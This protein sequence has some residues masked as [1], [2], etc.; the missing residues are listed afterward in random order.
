MSSEII[1]GVLSLFVLVGIN[2]FF[3]LAEY[4]LAVSRRTRIQELAANGNRRAQ[5]VA[6]AMED[7]DRFFAAVQIGVTLTSL[8]IGV[9]SEPSFSALIGL[10]LAPFVPHTPASEALMTIASGILGLLIAS[11]F[12]IVLAELTPRAIT[13]R[14]AE[15]IAL[16]V[17]PVMNA[18]AGAFQPFARLLR[19]SSM[20]VLRLMGFSTESA[21]ERLHTIEELKLIV[22]ASERG[23]AINAEQSDMLSGV[24]TLS[25]VSVREIMVPRTEMVCISV[26]ASLR[27]AAHLFA[28]HAYTR[29]P[30][31]EDSLDNIVGVLHVKNLVHA[32][33]CTTRE[34]S[35]RDLMQPP[36]FVPDTQRAD[37]L[38]HQ[39]R[40]RHEYMAIVL[41]EYGGTAGLVTLSDLVSLIIGEMQE[42]SSSADRRS[43]NIQAT[44]DGY[45]IK[46]LT[47]LGDVNEAFGLHLDDPHYDTI[48]G[49]VM[50]QLGRI[51]NV[52][53]VVVVKSQGISLTVEEMDKRRVA[54]VRLRRL[55]T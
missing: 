38:L 4:S 43:P 48:G 46:G 20:F 41:D 7:P 19:Q 44:A 54:K 9:L 42:E 51:P 23:G 3:V 55:S 49:Y 53:D 10:L 12:Q 25:D 14:R 17:V 36:F 31:Y 34:P 39:L 13:L 32:L 24:I 15:E 45:V 47:T 52:G 8:G 29:L 21:Q 18:I 1:W 33:L 11:Y 27:E 22:E 2:A 50:G 6:R 30:V 40:E 16:V 5:A 26:A 37:E 35:L 28:T